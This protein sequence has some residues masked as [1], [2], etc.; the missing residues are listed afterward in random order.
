MGADLAKGRFVHD[1]SQLPTVIWP[2]AHV[3]LD[4]KPHSIIQPTN[5]PAILT[6]IHSFSSPF[7]YQLYEQSVESNIKF[8]WLNT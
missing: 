3:E 1:S 8:K 2:N 7:N 5:Q 4:V 6:S